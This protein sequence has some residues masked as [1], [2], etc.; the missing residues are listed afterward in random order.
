M[1]STGLGA[2]TDV[3]ILR[4]QFKARCLNSPE[5]SGKALDGPSVII[6]GAGAF[7]AALALELVTHHKEKYPR[8]VD[9]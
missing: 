9:S 8:C 2:R 5:V 6:V 7:G 4:E 1:D 3:N